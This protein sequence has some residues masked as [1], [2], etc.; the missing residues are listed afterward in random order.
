MLRKCTRR[1]TC[2]KRSFRIEFMDQQ[3]CELHAFLYLVKKR[4]FQPSAFFKVSQNIN[5]SVYF[6]NILINKAKILKKH[7]GTRFVKC[8]MPLIRTS[9]RGYF[10]TKYPLFP[11]MS[12]LFTYYRKTGRLSVFV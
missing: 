7:K 5:N 11:N 1:Y 10:L 6:R 8:R 3:T 9:E 12:H 4:T 2:E